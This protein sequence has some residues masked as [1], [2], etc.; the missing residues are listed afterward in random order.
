[1]T[2]GS[3]LFKFF[4]EELKRLNAAGAVFPRVVMAGQEQEHFEKL[5]PKT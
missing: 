3:Q 4:I 5:K 1:M 2:N